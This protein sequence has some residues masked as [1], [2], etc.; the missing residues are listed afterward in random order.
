M[1][2]R[3]FATKIL[4]KNKPIKPE[5]KFIK[6]KQS[7]SQKVKTQSKK[8]RH[9]YF[10]TPHS[11]LWSSIT[12]KHYHLFEVKAQ[13]WSNKFSKFDGNSTQ[14]AEMFRLWCKKSIYN[15][16]SIF[17]LTKKR[18]EKKLWK[19]FF[20]FQHINVSLRLLW[21]FPETLK[22]KWKCLVE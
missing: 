6:K 19:H 22:E 18:K 20:S 3:T 5:H 10:T 4:Y 9:S 17:L 2:K 12:K 11:M 13:S 14:L 21:R 1:Q 15:F 16:E 7:V 8:C